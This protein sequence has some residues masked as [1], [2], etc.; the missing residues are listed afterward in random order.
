[1][2][3]TASKLIAIALAEVGYLEKETNKNLD[4]KTANAGD[5]NYT[6]YARD[7][8][9]AGF[10][11][12]S[13]QGYAYCDVGHDWCH[14]KAADENKKVAED[15]ICQTGKLGAGCKYS[16][17]YY[18]NKG[19]FH[20]SNPIPGDTIF[21]YNSK[22]TGVAHTG[23]VVAVD[24]TYVHTV[25]FNT[26]GA[27]GVIANG[28]GVAKK[29][30]KLTY[31]RIY[32]YGRPMYDPEEITA[33]TKGEKTVNIEMRVLEKG[34]KGDDVLAL[35]ILLKGHGCNG[36]MAKKLDG[37]FGKNTKGAVELFQKKHGLTVDGI[38][39]E[40]TWAKLLNG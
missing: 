38:V 32:G 9:K 20:K 13:K 19:R 30:Y 11:N 40:K 18:K 2:A 22:K 21:F 36:N 24:S 33:E 23:I 15:T 12:G 6:K 37:I 5:E 3:Y 8:Y 4:S 17:Q 26:S 27:S 14:W 29:K 7:L 1:M 10:Y 25:E 16:A 34:S 28:G 39:G 35:Q 31:G